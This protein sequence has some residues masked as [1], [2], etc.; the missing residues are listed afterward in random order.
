[1]AE[2]RPKYKFSFLVKDEKKNENNLKRHVYFDP[3][4]PYQLIRTIIIARSK[5]KKN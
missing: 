5:P 4:N 3:N 1:M 2:S